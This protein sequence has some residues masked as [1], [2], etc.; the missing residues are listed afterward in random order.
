MV[1]TI[2]LAYI[3][4]IDKLMWLDAQGNHWIQ[5][6]VDYFAEQTDG[7]CTMCSATLSSG[8]LCLDGGDEICD[9]H[10]TLEVCARIRAG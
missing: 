1:H 6:E 3:S 2:E 8:W 9:R 10:V 4:G 5:F 7:V